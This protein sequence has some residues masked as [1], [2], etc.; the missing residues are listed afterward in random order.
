MFVKHQNAT[1]KWSTIYKK[2]K[3]NKLKV[4]VIDHDQRDIVKRS[5]AL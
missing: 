4:K 5:M 1:T 2:K 3:I